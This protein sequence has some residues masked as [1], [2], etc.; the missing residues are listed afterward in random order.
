MLAGCKTVHDETMPQDITLFLSPKE[1][2][3]C[4]K[5]R[6]QGRTI[7]SARLG[8]ISVKYE[9]GR[10]AGGDEIR[11][12]ELIGFAPCGNHFA[13]DT[14]LLVTELRFRRLMQREEIQH[15]I[16]S[17][18]GFYIS[19]GS[20]SNL[21]WMGLA[22]LEGCHFA[23]AKK[24]AKRYRQTCFFIHLDGTNEGGKYNHFVVREGMS[25]NVLYAEKIVSES[26]AAI[27]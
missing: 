23:Q 14:I 15:H 8:Q 7:K 24:L 20:I 18:S 1:K 12:A 6:F 4:V 27:C 5:T 19:T 13:Y 25:G 22:Y 11:P 26:E 2:N 17:Q 16:A 3:A 9:V 10:T 21:S